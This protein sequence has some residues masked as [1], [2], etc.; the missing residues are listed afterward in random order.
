MTEA[1]V[2][3]G[4]N[5]TEQLPALRLQLGAPKL[6][7]PPLDVKVTEPAGVLCPVPPPSV[8]VTVQVEA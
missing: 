1:V 3:L 8:T 6:P 2:E 7:A 4:V 5:V